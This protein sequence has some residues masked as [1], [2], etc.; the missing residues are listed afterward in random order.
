MMTFSS[1]A[2]SALRALACLP[3]KEGKWVRALDISESCGVPLP[4]LHKI[5]HELGKAGL[6][7]SKK[8][9]LGGV[10]LA[11]PA[12]EV[13]LL[14]IVDII[15]GEAWKH[16]CLLSKTRCREGRCC[17]LHRL[18]ARQRQELAEELAY[19]TLDMYVNYACAQRQS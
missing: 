16:R 17:A 11:R 8:G 15:D 18:W 3:G 7:R 9:Y 14:D 2:D 6:L 12:A 19:V 5:L 10:A 13:S 1:R 4:Y